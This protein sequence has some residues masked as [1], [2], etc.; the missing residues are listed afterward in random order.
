MIKCTLSTLMGIHKKT[1]MDIHI[2]TKINRTTL[3]NLYHEKFTRIDTE[4]LNKLCIYFDC[5]LSA[6]LE[7]V[8]DKPKTT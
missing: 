5:P 6:L 2:A 8:K 1:I 4:T 7:H 3:S